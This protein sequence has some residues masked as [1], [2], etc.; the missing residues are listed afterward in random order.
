MI[1][2]SEGTSSSEGRSGQ[3]GFSGR[4]KLLILTAGG[5]GLAPIMPGT[6]GTLAGIPITLGLEPLLG[7][8]LGGWPYALTLLGLVLC[9]IG[10]G[11]GLGRWA[12]GYFGQKDAGAIVL[13]EVAG[14]LVTIAIC[15]LVHGRHPGLLGHICAFVLFRVVDITKPWPGKMCERAPAGLG[16]MLDDVVLALYSGGALSLL[17]LVF[18]EELLW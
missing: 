11:V 16:V 15:V 5:L 7:S 6:F 13:D 10:V 18:P 12:E 8:S 4:L 2:S 14:Y 9:M 17:A 3:L 1:S